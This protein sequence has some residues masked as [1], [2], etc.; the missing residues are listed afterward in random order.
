M[1]KSDLN[2]L[3]FTVKRLFMKLFKSVNIEL[4]NGCRIVFGVKLLSELI[5][6]R[7]KKLFVSC[8]LLTIQ[9]LNCW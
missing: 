3:D 1:T 2:A 6:E 5:A 8:L 7:M 4:I 9:L